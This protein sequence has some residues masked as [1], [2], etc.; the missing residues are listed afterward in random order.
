MPRKWNVEDLPAAV[1]KNRSV[2]GVLLTLG[3][4]EAGGNYDTIRQYVIKL[5][6]DTSHWVGMG[7][8]KGT[9][10]PIKPA[11]PLEKIL[12]EDSTYTNTNRLRG[13]LIREGYKEHRCEHC[14][15]TEWMGGPIPLELEHTNGDRHDHRIENLEV[16]CPNC[17]A[18]TPTHRGKNIGR[19]TRGSGEIGS[20]RRP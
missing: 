18:L 13:R 5:D 7:W 2:R 20:T 19:Y 11:I 9:T 16:I 14:G 4:V 15:L 3:L 6:L 8:R 17:H 1:M 10:I 12:V